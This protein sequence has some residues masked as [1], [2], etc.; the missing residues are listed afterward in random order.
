MG[1][2]DGLD[3]DR[4]IDPPAAISLDFGREAQKP[5]T[6]GASAGIEMTLFDPIVDNIGAD[7]QLCGYLVYGALVR[8]GW[9]GAVDVGDVDRRFHPLTAGL[10]HIGAER[11]APAVVV[12]TAGRK[13]AAFD[14]VGNRSRADTQT[15]GSFGH[16]DLSLL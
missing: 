4:C 5:A 6:A 1:F 14:P 16:G 2:T 15:T 8:C 12:T 3:V 10:L 11:D 9:L 13:L 7:P